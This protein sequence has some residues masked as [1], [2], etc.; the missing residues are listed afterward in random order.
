M[1]S[2]ELRDEL[3]CSICLSVYADPVTL[4]CGH[5]FCRLCI[6]KVLFTQEGSGVYT[7]PECRAEFRERPV[8]HRNMKLC[9]IAE[10]FLS[11]HPQQEVS[12]IFCTYCVHAP[13][14]AA[15]TCLHCEASLCDTHL[16]VHSTSAEH[17][18]TEP[19][20]FTD[21]AKCPVHREVL[22][23]YCTQD[24]ACICV[25]CCVFGEHRG[26]QVELVTEAF[27]KKKENLRK[28]LEK[29]TSNQEETEKKVQ[30]LQERRREV[31]EKAEGV[32]ERVTKLFKDVREQ[33]EVLE[34]RVLGDV[35]REEEKISLQISDLIQQLELKKEELSRKIR[36]IEE[37]CHITDPLTLLQGWPSNRTRDEAA[38]AGEDRKAC[39]EKVPVVGDLDEVLI[40]MTLH[41]ALA[42]IVTGM[43]RRSPVPEASDLFLDG[44]TAANSV[45]ISGDL[46][47]A[48]WSEGNQN[49]PKTP[50]RFITFCQVL[51]SRTFSSGQ[52]YWEVETSQLGNWRVG[53]AYP[54]M[55]RK[56][57][58][59]CIGYNS[60][61]WCLRICKRDYSVIHHSK[62]EMLT[63]ESPLQ[64]L[65]VYLDY[66]AG[67]LSFYQLG[68]PI[69]HLHTFTARFTEPLHAA[70]IVWKNG[71]VRI[72]S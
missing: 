57:D 36:H 19:T 2:A 32:T 18:L 53:V 24:V 42:E 34:R 27:E 22:K 46:K 23:Y 50:K 49:R 52:H 44:N 3:N 67:R 26:H 54:S 25:S 35:S 40:S 71:W 15:R 38:M 64:R 16:N 1:A 39:G 31:Q 6:R 72:R 62:E 60:K 4:S 14:P 69:R 7:C 28:V 33:L 10:R 13:V 66:E 21:N 70:F 12:G 58:N 30:G 55:E 41:T 48:S 17:V 63:T 61:S 20:S 65:G 5:N 45:V 11:T 8:L 56:G 9:S 68:D 43:R 37:L 59:S 51:S 29:L 47:T